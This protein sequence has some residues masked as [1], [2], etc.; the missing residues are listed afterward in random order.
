M[1]SR[2]NERSFFK[3]PTHLMSA[4]AAPTLI[5]WE[6]AGLHLDVTEPI[7]LL[8]IAAFIIFALLW[9][10]GRKAKLI[11]GRLQAF[12]EMI[13]DFVRFSL[14]DD[15]IGK[16]G[17]PWFPFIATFF[18]FIFIS[19]LLGLIPGREPATA[20]MG[21]TVAWAV[22]VF[23][24]YHIIGIRKHGAF[25]YI[26]GLVPSGMPVAIVPILF[27]LELISHLLRP[28][29]LALRLFANMV[30]GH[31]VLAVFTTLAMSTPWFIKPFPFAGLLIMYSFEIFVA[32]MQAYIF[33][34]LTALYINGAIHADH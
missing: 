13:V 24:V 26:K 14:V 22:I 31:K 5:K 1:A 20:F 10:A 12:V 8:F 16:E 18:L 2:N 34:L 17:K 33:T 11:P 27:I 29:T 19:N 21:T 32:G 9:A 15:M 28:L 3:L 23:F 7:L 4:A 30:A 25:S 6:I